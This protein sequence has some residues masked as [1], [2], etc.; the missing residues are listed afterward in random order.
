MANA[1]RCDKCGRFF[2]GNADMQ[3]GLDKQGETILRHTLGVK[4][5]PEM[6]EGRIYLKD[7][8]NACTK[9]FCQ[10]FKGEV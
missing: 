5:C 9:N 6:Q 3:V 10:W 8:C 1:F 7:L 4:F 2:D